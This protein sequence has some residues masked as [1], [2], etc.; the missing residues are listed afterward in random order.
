MWVQWG[1]L[2]A[3]D[4]V[5]VGFAVQEPWKLLMV[6]WGEVMVEVVVVVGLKLRR[7]AVLGVELE[8]PVAAEHMPGYVVREKA[9]VA[10]GAMNNFL[11][12]KA[13]VVEVALYS[14]ELMCAGSEENPLAGEHLHPVGYLHHRIPAFPGYDPVYYRFATPVP[15]RTEV[16]RDS[17]A[18]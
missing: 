7:T 8:I 12:E 5:V 2:K 3:V 16:Q 14:S 10:A 4:L 6:L 13:V 1:L 15:D 18:A 9:A 11:A 17:P